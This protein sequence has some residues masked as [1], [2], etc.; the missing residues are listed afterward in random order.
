MPL[1]RVSPGRLT[2]NIEARSCLINA[3]CLPTNVQKKIQQVTARA[4]ASVLVVHSASTGP[5]T[6]SIRVQGNCTPQP[7]LALEAHRPRDQRGLLLIPV[8]SFHITDQWNRLLVPFR[9]IPGI[10]RQIKFA[11]TAQT[12]RENVPSTV[13]YCS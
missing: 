13:P 2:K 11:F 4:L 7:A 1:V 6:G 3:S 9:T 12:F 5:R 8:A 10:L